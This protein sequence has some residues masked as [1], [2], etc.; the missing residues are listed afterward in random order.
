M[1]D[2]N[3]MQHQHDAVKRNLKELI[4]A[5]EAYSASFSRNASSENLTSRGDISQQHVKMLESVKQM[6]SAV[7]GPL[8]MVMLHYE[9]CLRSSAFRT[10]LEMGV[11]DTLPP[12]GSA[13]T[14][15]ELAKR[16]CVDDVL[17]VRLMRI[18]VPTFFKEPIPELYTHTPN[19]LMFLDSSVR[20]NFKMMFDEICIAAVNMSAFFKKNGY[21]NP[22]SQRN[23]PY[24]YAHDTKGLNMFEFILTDPARFKNFN[25]AMK[26]KSAQASLPYSLFPFKDEM[27]KIQTT[28]ETV[29][30]VDV[31]GGNGQASVAIRDFCSGVKGRMILQDQTPVL[32]GIGQELPGVEK[33]A[34]DFF[35]PQ[36][37]IG[38]LFYYIHR[39]LHDWPENECVMILKNIAAAMVPGISRLL[40]SEIVMPRG[41]TDIQTA[42]SDVNMLTFSGMER[43]ERQWQTLL[44][45]S[46]LMLVNT[47]GEAGGSNFRVLEAILN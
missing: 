18:V 3:M 12:D 9:E 25:D 22:N 41:P 40:I 1:N 15:K 28:D 29:L 24:T 4:A 11:F 45:K 14:L 32:D 5:V 36:P 37:I 44:D 16:L 35:N 27:N 8:N 6:Q 13:M 39:C 19:S 42:W 17:L 33:M 20:A 47:H 31:G 43:T 2:L 21:Q 23:N 38:A 10:L 7:Y 30:V 34:H 26:A 46:N